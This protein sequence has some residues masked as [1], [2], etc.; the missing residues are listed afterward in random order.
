VIQSPLELEVNMSNAESYPAFT[1]EN[2]FDDFFQWLKVHQLGREHLLNQMQQ[3]YDLGYI[4]ACTSIWLELD[5]RI[6]EHMDGT[7]RLGAN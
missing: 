2:F 6:Q 4:N 5:R 3:P 7:D 1:K